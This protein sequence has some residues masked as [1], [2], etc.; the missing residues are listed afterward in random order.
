MSIQN[1]INSAIGA[2]AGA[3]VAGKHAANKKSEAIDKS[4]EDLSFSEA[5]LAQAQA[6]SAETGL[7]LEGGQKSL[8]AAQGAYDAAM[9]KRYG[10]KGNTKAKIA[11]AQEQ[12]LNDLTAAQRAFDVLS[13]KDKAAK[14]MESRWKE[15]RENAYNKLSKLTGGRR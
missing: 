12:A 13:L 10:G 8:D 9:A 1:S 7:A 2:V 11:E 4:K 6:Q 15:R 14:A 3:V 5:E